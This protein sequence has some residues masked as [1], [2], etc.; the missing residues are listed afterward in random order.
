VTGGHLVPGPRLPRAAFTFA[1]ATARLFVDPVLSVVFPSLCVH[2]EKA[3]D[4]PRRG[5]L[6]SGCWEDLPRHRGQVCACGQPLGAPAPCG[7]CR[8]GLSP[9]ARG[10]SLGPY[11]GPLRSVLHAL[12]YGDQTRAAERL[13]D[14]LAAD[15]S[16]RSLGGADT[17]LVPVPLHPRRRNERGYNQSELLARALSRRLGLGLAAGALVRRKDTAPQTGLSAAARRQN[18]SGAFAVRRRALVV[19][20]PVILVDDVF[21][22]GATARACALALRAAGAHEVR[23]L[24]VARVP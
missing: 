5:P 16:V 11:E 1:E 12:K 19:D 20:R 6:C 21:T 18:V 2:C 7:R 8:R 9:I 22:T 17:V 4:L 24:T 15:P 14:A 13:A 10:A 3:R 23:L